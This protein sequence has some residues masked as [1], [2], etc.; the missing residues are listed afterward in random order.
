VFVNPHEIRGLA[1]ALSFPK[2][3]ALEARHSG[4]P[5]LPHRSRGTRRPFLTRV[6]SR[7]SARLRRAC[8]ADVTLNNVRMKLQNGANARASSGGL[9]SWEGTL[10]KIV[11]ELTQN[12]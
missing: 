7:V 3:R 2:S 5:M 4:A 6:P 9:R 1:G 11:E 12:G 10:G 8:D